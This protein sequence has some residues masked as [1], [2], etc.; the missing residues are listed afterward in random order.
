MERWGSI[1]MAF[2]PTAVPFGL[3]GNGNGGADADPRGPSK[4]VPSGNGN[5][6]AVADPRVL[7]QRAF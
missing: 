2:Q 7:S 1:N 4:A 5:D 3:T 6:G